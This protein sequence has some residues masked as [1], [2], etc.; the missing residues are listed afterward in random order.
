MPTKVLNKTTTLEER[1]LL[2]IRQA[3]RDDMGQIADFVRSSAEWYRPFVDE[4][5]MA[6]HEVG[7]AWADENFKKR[8][9]YVGPHRRRRGGRHDFAA[10]LR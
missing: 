10:I 9:F 4:K 7:E 1:P 5:D 2:K 6:E 3:R 8:D